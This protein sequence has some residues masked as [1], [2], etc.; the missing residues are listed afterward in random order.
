MDLRQKVVNAFRRRFG[1]DP[2]FVARAPG[3]VNLLGEHLDYNEGFVLPAAI[4]RATV[5]AARRLKNWLAG[6]VTLN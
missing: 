6:W 1:A 5:L 4:D 3:R 2:E